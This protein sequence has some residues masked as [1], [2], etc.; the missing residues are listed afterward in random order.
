MPKP[1]RRRVR[2]RASER[3]RSLAAPPHAQQGGDSAAAGGSA[4]RAVLAADGNEA[5]GAT[6]AGLAESLQAFARFVRVDE[7]SRTVSRAG[8][9]ERQSPLGSRCRVCLLRLLLRER[10]LDRH[11][12]GCPPGD[13]ERGLSA[14]ATKA[15]RPRPRGELRGEVPLRR[16][17]KAD[18]VAPA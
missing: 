2:S 6:G 3:I 18:S 15:G 1:P 9:R 17:R 12:S 13:G 4:D 8:S 14:P 7:Q 5:A 11:R 16:G 10:E